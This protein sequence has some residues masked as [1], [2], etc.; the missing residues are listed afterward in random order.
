MTLT[1]MSPENMSS[2][3]PP[4]YAH[5]QDTLTGAL[6]LTEV[7]VD[8]RGCFVS[9]NKCINQ[10]KNIV[11]GTEKAV[12]ALQ[13]TSKCALEQ[14]YKMVSTIN[15]SKPTK[16]CEELIGIIQKQLNELEQSVGYKEL[17]DI[18][19]HQVFFIL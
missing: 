8:L 14:A 7:G 4:K 19:V 15:S 3:S 5:V 1:V 12:K 6:L 17:I 13:I 10:L 2:K 16:E 18:D 11:N 9:G